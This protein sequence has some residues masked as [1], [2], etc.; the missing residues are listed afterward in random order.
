MGVALSDDETWAMVERSPT[1]IVTTLDRDGYPLSLP[2][3]FVVLGRLIYFRTPATSK[4]VARIARDG[5]AGFLV[6]SGGRWVELTAV[7][8]R[9]T[10]ELV[11][12]EP[13]R[14]QVMAARAEK[15]RGRGPGGGG[16]ALPEATVRHYATES[17]II[18][19][20]PVGAP[21]TWDNSKIRRIP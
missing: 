20:T 6:E 3:W 17:A 4:K 2:V 8:F 16:G 10:A 1:G 21:I 5:R 12:D 15:Y 18:R 9:A 19:L 14:A 13:L 11:T 7:S